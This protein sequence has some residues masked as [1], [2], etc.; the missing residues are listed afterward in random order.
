MVACLYLVAK[1]HYSNHFSGSCDLFVWLNQEDKEQS[2]PYY[3]VQVI[4][5]F[6][7]KVMQQAMLGSVGSS[8]S[9]PYHLLTNR[10]N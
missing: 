9:N 6:L 3:L 10:V 1:S 7:E 2:S 8:S 5:D 4:N